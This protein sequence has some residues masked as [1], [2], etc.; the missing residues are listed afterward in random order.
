MTVTHDTSTK[1]ATPSTTSGA[2]GLRNPGLVMSAGGK[3]EVKEFTGSGTA[4]DTEVAREWQ[5]EDV[6]DR[7]EKFADAMKGA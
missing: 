6:R 3:N 5:Y 1:Q 2:W 4:I 7:V